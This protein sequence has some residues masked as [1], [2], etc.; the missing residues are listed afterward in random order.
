MTNTAISIKQL[1][2]RYR[3]GLREPYGTFRDALTGYITAPFRRLGGNGSN[4]VDQYFW[5]LKS[6]SFEVEEGEVLGI[7][8]P[9][10]SGKSTLLKILSRITTPT[11]GIAELHGRVGS[12]L[13]VG[14]GFH[15]ELTGRENIFLSGSILG[16]RKREIGDKFEEIAKFSEIDKFLDTPVKRYSSGMYVR[17]A[18][19]VAAHLDPEI[20]MVDEVLAVG[21]AAFQKKCM[22]K[23]KEVS[24]EGRTV[25]FV[26]HNMG[27]IRQLCTKCVHIDKGSLKNY[28]TSSEI[29]DSYLN[30]IENVSLDGKSVFEEDLTKDFQLRAA[31]VH[32]AEGIE[33]SSFDCDK[34]LFIEFICQ[35]NKVIPGL[36]GYLEVRR[37]DGTVVM[38]SDSFDTKPNPLD[39]LGLGM[40]SVDI[41]IPPRTLGP[42]EYVVY[43]NF[44][45][46]FSLKG[47]NVESPG[48]VCSFKLYDF[49]S[50]RGNN[51]P[52][53][54]STALDWRVKDLQNQMTVG[55]Y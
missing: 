40:H 41:A 17:L 32:N 29:V 34:P 1:G 45:S 49:T 46:N 47:F 8:G 23:M 42:G 43:I 18:F 19:A 36:Y 55:N 37:K 15:P 13:E 31:Q 28:G 22:G 12:L 25:L 4:D 26:S 30:A 44:T 38:C 6:I 35:A 7:I 51:R 14:T 24:G 11:E 39:G 16:M 9:N 53:F 20:L 33:A 3:I 52:G 2:K 50:Y 54:F 48:I 10:G 27:A 21:D 5:A